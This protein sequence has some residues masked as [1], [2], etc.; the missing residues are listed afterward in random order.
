MGAAIRVSQD[1]LSQGGSGQAGGHWKQR[2]QISLILI[3][4]VALYAR[5]LVDF[6]KQHNLTDASLVGSWL[7]EPGA[8][9]GL[10]IPP[11]ALYLA[12]MRRKF[13]LDQPAKPDNRG[14]WLLGIACL[15]YLVGR[16]GAELFLSRFSLLVLLAGLTWTFWGM[17]R[18]RTLLF[19][20]LLLIT[21]IPLPAL[22]Y[23]RLAVP[24]QLM[25]SQVS[26]AI[27]Q[28]MGVSLYRDGN[29]ITL[30]HVS[31]GV[32]E[33]CS[34][35][36]SLAALMVGSLLLGF[37]YCSQTLPRT[38]LFLLSV[39]IAIGVNVLRVTGTALL[40]DYQP[41][42][43]MGFYHSFSSWL[44]FLVGFGLTLALAKTLHTL[45][46]RS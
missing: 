33:A 29:I 44:I 34:G 21:M 31:L 43:A 23:N 11:L 45:F 3:L 40:A 12:W 20:F 4:I 32:A 8:S 36:H 15:I 26:T 46:E 27:A 13:T 30:A 1:K 41:E 16:L 22:L 39:P 2:L 28:T 25:A 18:L 9:H 17:A 14:L 7:H 24:L 5:I 19:P 6:D 38:V 35:L 10:L 37:L 42:L